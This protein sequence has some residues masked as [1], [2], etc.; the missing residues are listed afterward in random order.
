MRGVLPRKGV[1]RRFFQ[2]SSIFGRTDG[3]NLKGSAGRFRGMGKDDSRHHQASAAKVDVVRVASIRFVGRVKA[4]TGQNVIQ[5]VGMIHVKVRLG[6]VERR[7]I[8][9]RRNRTDSASLPSAP[10]APMEGPANVSLRTC[11]DGE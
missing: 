7:G 6:R 9:H 8:F 11:P 10:V 3:Q 5:G 2:V 4:G 1:E